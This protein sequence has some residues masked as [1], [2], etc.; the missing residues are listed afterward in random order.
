VVVI[1]PQLT[2]V[3]PMITLTSKIQYKNFEAGEFVEEHKRTYEETIR[4]I[5]DYPWNIQRKKIIVDLTSPSVTIEGSSGDYLKLAV[6]YNQKFVLLYLNKD[7][8]LFS[9]SF[10]NL[11]DGYAYIKCFFEKPEFDLTGFK[12]ESTWFQNNLTHFITQDFRYELTTQS[13]KKYWLSARGFN[14]IVPATFLIIMAVVFNVIVLLWPGII[15]IWG[16]VMPLRLFFIYYKHVKD[17]I[18]IMSKA[19]STFYFGSVD[20]M[21]KYDKK[22]ILKYTIVK[23]TGSRSIYRG[24]AVVRIEFKNGTLLSLPNLLIDHRALENKLFECRKARE[25]KSPYL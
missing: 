23:T 22:D 13:V 25:D 7:K 5:E 3:F 16:S 4:L 6:Y 14:I 11:Q 19:N 15:L 18:L 9:R 12:K 10:I 1:I 20:N 17:K 8:R 24:Y 2:D 21:V